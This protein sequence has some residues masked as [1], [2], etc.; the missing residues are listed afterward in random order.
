M[1]D[2]KVSCFIAEDDSILDLK[3][4]LESELEGKASCIK[5]LDGIH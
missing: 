4:S 1:R 3:P 5:T 2:G